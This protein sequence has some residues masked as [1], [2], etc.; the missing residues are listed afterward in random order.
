[1]AYTHTDKHA[2]TSVT[3]SKKAVLLIT[4]THTHNPLAH[5]CQH[6]H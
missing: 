4:H 3:H 5:T 1:M 6:T 2:H